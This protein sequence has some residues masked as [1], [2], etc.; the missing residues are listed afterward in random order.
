MQ[1]AGVTVRLDPVRGKNLGQFLSGE[2]APVVRQ[3]R[4]SPVAFLLTPNGINR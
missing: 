1:S 4:R 3:R 2:A